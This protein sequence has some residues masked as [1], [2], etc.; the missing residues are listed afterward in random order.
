MNNVLKSGVLKS[1]EEGAFK[2]SPH[3]EQY[4]SCSL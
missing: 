1:F 2:T 3:K 4:N